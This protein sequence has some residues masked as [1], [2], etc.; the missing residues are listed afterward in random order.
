MIRINEELYIRRLNET[1]VDDLFEIYSDKETVRYLL[2][3]PWTAE[4][5]D[6]EAL[7]RIRLNEEEGSLGLGVLCGEK[8]I[9]TLSVWKKEM[10]DTYEIGYVFH[11]EFRHRG[12][13]F[14]ALS[15]LI[16]YLFTETNAHRLYAVLDA[17]NNDSVRLLERCGFVK[18]AYFRKDYFSKGEWTDT[19]IY[20]ML[21]E[22]Y[23]V[24]RECVNQR[25]AS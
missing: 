16:D 19:L 2:C 18:E 5:K 4:H 6:E 15:K 12:Y 7:K 22:D 13:A 24:R 10:K 3:E 14:N 9:G 1:D 17:R 20:A 23:A 25:R 21:K 11:P 8:L